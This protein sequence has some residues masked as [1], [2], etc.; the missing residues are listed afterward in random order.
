MPR[1]PLLEHP[2][3]HLKNKWLHHKCK[4]GRTP[5]GTV[6]VEINGVKF[7]FDFTLGKMVKS[8]YFGCYDYEIRRMMEKHLK[9]GGM[10]IDVGANIG[11]FTAIGASLVG[12]AG[13]VHSF[14]PV[15]TLFGYLEQITELN[16][17]YDIIVNNIGLGQAD[18][19]VPIAR[20]RRNM[21]G[22]SMV[23]GF[24]PKEDT[25]ESLTVRVQRLDEY[26][27]SKGI[28][29]VSLM[30]IDTEGFE[31]PVLLGNSAFFDQSRGELPPVIVEVAPRALKLIGRSMAELDEFMATYG[32]KSYAICGR[33]RINL[34]DIGDQA[35]IVFRA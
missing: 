24:V 6:T 25:A 11:Y 34:N 33:H 16:P 26:L 27:K 4:Y 12:K 2:I 31:L 28:S 9:P 18:Q 8:M 30:K 21:G 23:P 7:P 32:Y 20:H 13:Q 5:E 17:E 1:L 19:L 3:L 29:R 14:E 22:S 10:F 35:N 15:S